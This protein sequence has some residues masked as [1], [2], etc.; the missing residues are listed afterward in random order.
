M[1]P[2]SF[3][4]A[5]STPGNALIQSTTAASKGKSTRTCR[6][7]LMPL[8]CG[9]M[10]GVVTLEKPAEIRDEEHESNEELGHEPAKR[11]SQAAHL[12]DQDQGCAQRD[13]GD[14]AL[15]GD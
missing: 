3:I 6:G 15:D 12:L 11:S 4:F 1:R 2:I 7:L 10:R 13:D 5:G 9:G 14:E 8:V